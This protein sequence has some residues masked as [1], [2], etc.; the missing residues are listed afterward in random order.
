MRLF[1]YSQINLK[2]FLLC[3]LWILMLSLGYFLL[4]KSK[5]E[6]YC[7]LKEQEAHL[8]K[9]FETKEA[10]ITQLLSEK[11]WI[12]LAKKRFHPVLNRVFIRDH[13]PDLLAEISQ[14]G[15]HLAVKLHS[16][17]PQHWR[18]HRGY[19]EQGIQLSVSGNYSHLALFINDM[20]KIKPILHLNELSIQRN[21]SAVSNDQL[22]MTLKMARYQ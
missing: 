1:I 21:D 17:S 10:Q 7:I 19:T 18:S 11:Q 8:K 9:E 16:F 15:E 12:S 13:R 14:L 22:L 3:A 6:Q 4:V 5:L 2:W 20:E